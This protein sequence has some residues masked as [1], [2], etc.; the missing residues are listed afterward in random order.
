MFERLNMKVIKNKFFIIFVLLIIFIVIMFLFS[1]DNRDSIIYDGK[2]YFYLEY[3]ED[4]FYYY[5]CN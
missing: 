4:I 3:N 1:Y 5:Q 2:E